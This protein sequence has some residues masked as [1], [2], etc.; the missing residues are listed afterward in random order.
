M[1]V[2]IFGFLC[3]IPCV[4]FAI[5]NIELQALF[6]KKAVLMIDGVR[7]IVAVGNKSPEGVKLISVN[8]SGVILEVNEIEKAYK[9]GSAVSLT[10]AKPE[11]VEEKIFANA[12]GMFLRTGTINGR[13]VKFLIDTGATTIAMNK[14]QAKRLGIK[15]RLEGKSSGAS[16][17]SG[18]VK[19]FEV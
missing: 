3:L 17:A 8:S 12:N 13:T 10:F 14:K 7:R 11:Q 9:I 1:K 6:G 2:F 16:T 15:Y 18:Y 5:E 19:A 4:S